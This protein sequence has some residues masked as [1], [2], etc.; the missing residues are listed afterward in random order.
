[1]KLR[2]LNYLLLFLSVVFLFR[3]LAADGGLSQYVYAQAQLKEIKQSLAEQQAQNA[4]L[5][6][7]VN[8]LQGSTEAIESLARQVLG[9]VKP[10]EVFIE[11]IRVPAFSGQVL[12]PE[13]LEIQP[14]DTVSEE[15]PMQIAPEEGQILP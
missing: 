11:V 6:Q 10:N 3:L 8:A 7:E 1:M 13:D 5:K 9:M 2:Q 4:A 12:R 15:P 14:E